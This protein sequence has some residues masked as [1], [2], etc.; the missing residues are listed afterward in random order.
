M[1]FILP[2]IVSYLLGSIPF[3]YIVPRFYGIDDIRKHGSGNIGATNV[4][5]ILG[6]K[7]AIW[8]YLGDI[9]KGVVAVLIGKWYVVAGY[10][11]PYL[12]NDAFW[13]ICV[14]A[15]VIGHIFPLFLKFKGG[16]GVNTVLGGMIALLPLETLMAFAVFGIVVVISK[17]IS[18]GSMIA[19]FAFFL[20]ISTEKFFMN[21]NIALIYVYVSGLIVLLILLTHR[22][23]ISRLFAGEENKVSKQS[24]PKQENSHV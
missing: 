15:A 2:I 22:Q 23:N 21:S 11:L 17:Y 7:A 12:S 19:S 8:V 6:F 9:S 18:L 20:I 24:N 10:S 13:L 1:F 14:L 16:K 3:G 5:R 4:T